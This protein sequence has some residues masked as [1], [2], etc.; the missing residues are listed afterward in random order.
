MEKININEQASWKVIAGEMLT[1]VFAAF[2]VYMLL[3]LTPPQ[4]YELPE[5]MAD[6][7]KHTLGV[8]NIEVGK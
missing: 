5:V 8:V 4:R 3:L 1:L 7:F 2:V 6:N